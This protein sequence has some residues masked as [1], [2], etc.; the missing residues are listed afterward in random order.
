MVDHFYD[1]MDGDPAYARLRAIHA[2]DL[3]PMRDSLAGFLNGWMG[4]PRD[5]FGSGKCVMSAHSP[6]QI[7]GELRDQWLS[8]MRQAMDRVA[9]DDDLRQTLDEGF[10]RVAAAMVRA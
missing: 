1:L 6:F 2:A 8:A 3:S 9:M 10:A 5:W 7:D 4:G